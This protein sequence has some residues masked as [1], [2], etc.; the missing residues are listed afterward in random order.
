MY[1]MREDLT[2]CLLGLLGEEGL[3]C[4]AERFGGRRLHIPKAISDDHDIAQAIGLKA[5]QRLSQRYGQ[6]VL[7]VPLARELRARHYRGI[8]KSNG[9]IATLLGM[10]ETGVDKLFSRMDAPPQKGS[11]QLSFDI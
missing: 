5:A 9:E 2:A 4:L 8:G 1:S 7:R 11:R 10:T 3:V 6:A